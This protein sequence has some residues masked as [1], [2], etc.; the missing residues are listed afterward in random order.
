MSRRLRQVTPWI[1]LAG[2]LVLASAGCSKPPA[3]SVNGSTNAPRSVTVARAAWQD[4]ERLV[5]VTGSFLAHDAATLSVKVPGRLRA[6]HVDLGSTVKAGE[7]IA[8]VDPTDYE[9]RVRQAEAAVAQ[10]RASLGLPLEGT[11]D[12][13]DVDATSAVRESR[14]VLE[15]S[16]TQRDRLRNL[17]TNGLVSA[18][19]LDT[20]EAAYKVAYNRSQSAAED[21]RTKLATLGQRR[22]E[23]AFAQK[24][25]SDTAMRAPFEGVIQRRE[26]GLGEYVAAGTPV[27]ALVRP[28]P[29]RLRLDI[30]EREAAAVRPGQTVRLRVEGYTNR[31]I[32]H[33]DRL[34]PALTEATRV[35]TV[36]SDVP[37]DGTLR[38][39]LFVRADI[40]VNS[41]DRGLTVPANAVLVFAGLEK[42]IVV[43]TDRAVE[44]PVTT[45]RTGRGWIEI[46][47]G[48]QPGEP[49]V[50]DPGGLRT[51]QPVRVAGER[52]ATAA[53]TA[54][55]WSSP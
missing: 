39:G 20:A 10:A 25:L 19:E 53:G 23:L 8:Q 3:G 44:R 15:E 35:L 33:I 21:A 38:P 24:Q 40:I 12:V 6:I 2:G 41:R 32:A 45:G 16:S 11:N 50:I 31:W 48:L 46:L 14:A 47:T 29:L 49:V 17:S 22:A 1:L 42:V 54:T 34:S 26:A 27:L 13:V 37:N 4:L 30:P 55:G 9:I 28:D 36:E 52:P 43:Q 7:V 18:S 5:T 51:G